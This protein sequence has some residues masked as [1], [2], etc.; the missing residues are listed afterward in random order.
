MKAVVT[1]ANRG[2][3][4]EL[5]QQLVARGDEVH[6]CVRDTNSA[7]LRALACPSLHLHDLDVRDTAK[8]TEF[9]RALGETPIDLVI[10]NAGVFGGHKQTHSEFDFAEANHAYDVN[11]LGA[12]RVSLA[13][14]P[15]LRRGLGKKLV[16]ITSGMGSISANDQGGSYAYRM[17]KAAL[18]QMSKGLAVD[19][20]DDQIISLVIHP[21]WVRTD[22]GGPDAPVVPSES[23]RGILRAIDAAT[24]ESSGEFFDYNG[25]QVPW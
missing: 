6:A 3:G 24:I 20:R 9:A 4:L 14:L 17:S 10:N 19:L 16:H 25:A 5:V 7:A 18:N 13:L 11:A 15:H 2:I 22:M 1:G 8:V 23:A 21:G 12:L